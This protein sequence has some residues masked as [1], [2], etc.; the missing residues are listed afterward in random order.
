M[1]QHAATVRSTPQ[2]R[3][4]RLRLLIAGLC[5]AALATTLSPLSGTAARADS[6]PGQSGVYAFGI[7]AFGELGS[8]TTNGTL[9]GVAAP[10]QIPPLSGQK[11]SVT[12]LAAGTYHSLVATSSGQLY[13]FGYNQY[14]EL[15]RADNEF[16]SNPNPTPE[17]VSLPGQN[18]TIAALAGGGDHSLALTSSGQLYAFGNNH[19]GQLGNSTEN[20]Q[21]FANAPTLV[22]LPGQSGTI[23]QI[24]AGANSSL[25]LTSTG[26]LYGFGL[27]LYGQIGNLPPYTPD[28]EPEPI[29]NPI[30]LPGVTGQITEIAAGDTDGFAATSTGQLFAFGK[31]D[32]GQLGT[33]NMGVENYN[34]TPSLITLPGESGTI[35]EIAAG[36]EHTLVLT[37]SGQLYG[38]GENGEGQLGYTTNNGSTAPTPTPA[39]ATLPGQKGAITQISAGSYT[40][41]A[42]T[43][44]GQLYAFGLNSGGA[45]GIQANLG[46]TNVNLPT[47][48]PLPGTTVD[49]VSRG[50]DALHSLVLV[51]NLAIG[52]SSLADAHVGASYS[53]TPAASGGTAPL[54]WSASGLPN[55]LSIDAA[56]GVISGTPTAAGS[57]HVTLTVTDAFGSQASVTLALAVAASSGSGP[58]APGSGTAGAPKVTRVHQSHTSWRLGSKLVSIAGAATP[59]GTTFSFALSQIARVTLAFTQPRAG[60]LV[61]GHCVAINATNRRRK[62]HCTRTTTLGTL[63]FKGQSGTNTVAFQGR[64]SRSLTLAPGTYTLVVKASANRKHS[65]PKTL[66]FT[67]VG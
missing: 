64:I 18:G 53:A 27:D 15:G 7:N 31:N 9:T 66:M 46:T 2:I 43:S 57:A 25:A 14:G 67:I 44:S 61:G 32:E 11:G 17:L 47:L 45:L 30:A 5:A 60:R 36:S 4:A 23:I 37:T 39:L 8:T 40:S 50:G 42:V 52:S 63:A 56:S 3:H 62:A 29:P 59:V 35:A 13:S 28:N 6:S 19:W 48:V 55:G 34:G 65:Q 12:T 54:R 22:T 24:A 33:T 51:S 26:Q 21:D 41:F 49:A 16:S 38:F 1:R 58:T 10:T 20:G